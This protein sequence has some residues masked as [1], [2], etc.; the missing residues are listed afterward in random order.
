MVPWVERKLLGGARMHLPSSFFRA[1]TLVL[2]LAC[3]SA[4]ALKA[5]VITVSSQDYDVTSVVGTYAELELTLLS[6][7]WWENGAVASSFAGALGGQLGFP[8]I[9]G[10]FA[11]LFLYQSNSGNLV[12]KAY[13]PFGDIFDAGLFGAESHTWAVASPVSPAGVPDSGTPIAM[14]G[15]ALGGLVAL[16]RRLA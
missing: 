8:N 3:L 9:T 4:P 13:T 12:A 14:L 16:R 15:L 7:P 2:A 11:P 1:R 5:V 10:L 6:Q